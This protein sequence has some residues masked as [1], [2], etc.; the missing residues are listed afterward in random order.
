MYPVIDYVKKWISAQ[1]SLGE[2]CTRKSVMRRSLTMAIRIAVIAYAMNVAAHFV[3]YWTDLLP[4]GLFPAL[5]LATCLTPPVSFI[6]AFVAYYV[7]GMALFELS[8][9][10][11]EFERI[12]RTDALS[13]LLNRRAFMECFDKTDNRAALVLFDIDRFKAVNDTYGHAAG[14]QVIVSVANSLSEAFADGHIVARFGG[15]E[16]T[17]LILGLTDRECQDRAD[18][19]RELVASRPFKFA[20]EERTTT[21]SAGISSCRDYPDFTSL[22][23]AADKALYLAKAS[24]RNR[25]MHEHE[26]A[27]LLQSSMNDE[28]RTG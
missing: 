14:D 18:K 25:V 11:R 21:V 15:E 9:S 16:F 2:F 1:L 6:V 3:L 7:V 23:S 12:S 4:Y 19:A 17:V 8:V 24:G 22:F 27:P 20:S 28:R 26:L 10:H 5:V 13:G